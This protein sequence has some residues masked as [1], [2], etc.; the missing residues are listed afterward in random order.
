MAGVISKDW[1]VWLSVLPA[2][3]IKKAVSWGTQQFIKWNTYFT[4]EMPGLYFVSTKE[5]I[6]KRKKERNTWMWFSC[7]G[8][9]YLSI[10][11]ARY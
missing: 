1:P 4:G 7:W 6:I 9:P 2:L 3:G 10:R 5:R 8:A 11:F